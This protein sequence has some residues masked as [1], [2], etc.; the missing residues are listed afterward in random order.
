MCRHFCYLGDPIPL[1]ELVFHAPHSLLVQSYAPKHMCG[2]GRINA[3]GFGV[4]WYTG[5]SFATRYR[6]AGPIWQDN[7]FAELTRRISAP[8]ILG[9]VRNATAGMPVS[10]GASAP[11][12][13]GSWLFSL[14][15]R[16][17]GWPD[18]AVPLA[19][20]LSTGDLLTLDAPTDAALLWAVL[21]RRLASHDDRSPDP[22][23]V[24]G[25]L[26]ADV[27]ATAP[28]SRLNLLLT[29]GT[30]SY[31]TT[32]THSLWVRTLPTGTVLASEPFDDD[33]GWQQVE[34][35]RLVTADRAGV[36]IDRLPG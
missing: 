35:G 12:T 4:G 24:L 25:E 17:D 14:N 34:D 6:R 15:G 3:D 13:D 36:V 10:D 33:P 26:V 30:N 1:G 5:D 8:A 23:E 7:G 28:S 29:N 31:A 16:I 11:F 9:A 32:V 19:E 20:E 18:S 27:L 22:A 2:G 21:R